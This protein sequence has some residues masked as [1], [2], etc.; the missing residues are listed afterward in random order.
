MAV[1]LA[2]SQ[3]QFDQWPHVAMLYKIIT[4][5]LNNETVIY[6]YQAIIQVL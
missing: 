4:Q 5:S 6:V 1:L 3:K 2:V